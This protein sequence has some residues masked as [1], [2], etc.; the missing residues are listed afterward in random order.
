MVLATFPLLAGVKNASVLFNP[1]FFV[2][3]A[4][5]LLQGTSVTLV[6]R[7]LRVIVPVSAVLKKRFLLRNQ[8]RKTHAKLLPAYAR[9]PIYD[10]RWQQD[11]LYSL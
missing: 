4:S 6:A 8:A 1:V 2:V 10:R 5:V 7:W 9:T 3:L 11:A